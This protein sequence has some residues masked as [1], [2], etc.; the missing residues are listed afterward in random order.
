MGAQ[1]DSYDGIPPFPTTLIKIGE[2]AFL[3]VT[4]NNFTFLGDAPAC[5]Y[6]ALGIDENKKTFEES[7]DEYYY[8]TYQVWNN[9]QV[10]ATVYEDTVGWKKNNR[11]KVGYPYTGTWHGVNL[12]SVPRQ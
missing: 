4:M 10:Y 5:G 8:W 6:A 9:I 1:L 7:D 11:D 3:G 2:C 12:V